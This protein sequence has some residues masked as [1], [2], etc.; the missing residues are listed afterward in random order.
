MTYV[1]IDHLA[2]PRSLADP[3][4][5]GESF[6]EAVHAVLPHGG[7][8]QSLWFGPEGADEDL[9]VDIDVEAGRA[10]LTWL[11]DDSVGVELAPGPPI[12]VM[13]SVDEPLVTV[14]GELARVSA[15]TARRAVIEY[16]TT[17]E[18]PTGVRWAAPGA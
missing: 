7:S 18:R 16:V 1:M 4:Q 11:A 15:E 8:G 14:P 2:H 6:D 17:G 13:W 10:A 12:T 5:A 9:R 3:A